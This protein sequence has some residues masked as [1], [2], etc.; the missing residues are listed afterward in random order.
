MSDI[1]SARQKTTAA[2]GSGFC[3]IIIIYEQHLLNGIAL[4]LTPI[5]I[6]GERHA[7]LTIITSYYLHRRPCANRRSSRLVT[8]SKRRRRRR[9]RQQRRRQFSCRSNS[10]R[11]WTCGAAGGGSGHAIRL[12]PETA[13][14]AGAGGWCATGRRVGVQPSKYGLRCKYW[15]P[16]LEQ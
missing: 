1:T 15:V 9:R 3:T 2:D 5:P 6:D 4:R 10:G 11:C 14:E 16:V 8:G 7:S 13:R 12:P